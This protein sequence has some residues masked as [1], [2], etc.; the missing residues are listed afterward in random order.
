MVDLKNAQIDVREYAKKFRGYLGKKKS[1][2]VLKDLRDK[3]ERY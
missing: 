1:D 2:F 3:K